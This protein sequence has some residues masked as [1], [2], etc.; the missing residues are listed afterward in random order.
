M[1]R[2][3]AGGGAGGAGGAGG[4]AVLVVLVV[5]VVLVWCSFEVF[6]WYS[7]PKR[8]V[9]APPLLLCFVFPERLSER[10]T[11]VW[12]FVAAWWHSLFLRQLTT[13]TTM[14]PTTTM[15]MTTTDDDGGGGGGG[16]DWWRRRLTSLLTTTRQRHWPASFQLGFRMMEFGGLRMDKCRVRVLRP[17]P[18][19]VVVLRQ[20]SRAKDRAGLESA[21]L[22]LVAMNSNIN[23]HG[24]TR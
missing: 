21:H 13:T 18:P 12:I 16:G 7:L 11:V 20:R 3:A 10:P 6:V 9:A 1:C 23:W 5:Q 14:T 22:S 17:T 8:T 2:R 15:T 19:P 4:G 24:A